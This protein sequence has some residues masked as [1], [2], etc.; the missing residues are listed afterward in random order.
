V[1][2][3]IP[4]FV[5]REEFERRGD[6]GHYLI[7]RSWSRGAEERFQFGKGLF[8]RIEVR[9]VRRQKPDVRPGRFNRGTDLRLL[10]NREVVEHDDVARPQRGHQDLF[11]VGAERGRVDGAIEDRR[12]GE[13]VDVQS[14]DDGVRLPMAARGV[15]MQAGAARA[16]AIPTQQI[17]GDAALIEKDVLVHIAQRLPCLPLA[18]GRCDIRTALFVGV[19]RF[20]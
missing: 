8:D 19:Y 4:A 2:D 13:P 15:V 14:G 11:D 10:M 18:T 9:T 5:R 20:F 3:V 1:P 17:G 16:A 7:E 12:R 6:K